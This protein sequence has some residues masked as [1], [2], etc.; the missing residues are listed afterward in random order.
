M[1]SLKKPLKIAIVGAGAI[2]GLIGSA[3]ALQGSHQVCAL[4]RGETLKALR[5]HGWRL[6]RNDQLEHCSANVSDSVDVLGIQ[7]VVVLA[8]KGPALASLAPQLGP[9]IGPTTL[10]VSAMNGVPWWFLDSI[11]K[12]ATA[13]LESVDPVGSVSKSLPGRQSA[14][15]VVHISAATPEPGLVQ[16]RAGNG[17]TLGVSWNDAE[18][19]RLDDAQV[20]R[21]HLADLSDALQSAGF[22]VTRSERIRFDI[23]YK[24]WGN[25]TVNPI[26]AMTGAWTDELLDDELVREF[27]NA[28]MLEAQAVGNQIGCPIDQT[29]QDRNAIT[30]KLGRF[31]PS[32]L[33]DVEANRPIELDSLVGVVREIAVRAGVATPKLDFLYGLVRLFARSRGLYPR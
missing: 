6:H 5:Q 24:L 20:L 26:T 31:K 13:P 19:S 32:M 14:G 27:C 15:C 17:L 21:G 12:L 1:T 8:V 30:R 33:Q 11:P 18:H 9:L 25:M 22:A 23:W 10:I 4:A 28:C 29:P 7:D 16:V 2:G 3:L